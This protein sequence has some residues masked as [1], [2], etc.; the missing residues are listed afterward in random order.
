[1][2]CPNDMSS[3]TLMC[4]R[5]TR[6][7]RGR[8]PLSCKSGLQ[9]VPLHRNRQDRWFCV[10][11]SRGSFKFPSPAACPAPPPPP[12]LSTPSSPAN[13]GPPWLELWRAP[14]T[15]WV[16]LLCGTYPGYKSSSFFDAK[17]LASLLR[18]TFGISSTTSVNQSSIKEICTHHNN[19]TASQQHR[20]EQKRK[21]C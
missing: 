4:V 9:V 7:V 10:Y 2:I 1:M 18:S 16:G 21:G 6:C 3:S 8:V 11:G 13:T 19:T 12:S 15:S 14:S 17:P 20:Q 5:C